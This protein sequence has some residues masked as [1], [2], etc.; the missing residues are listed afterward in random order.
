MQIEDNITF[1][2]DEV[3]NYTATDILRLMDKSAFPERVHKQ[4][5]LAS[6]HYAKALW[7]LRVLNLGSLL[8]LRVPPS[9]M[10]FTFEEDLSSF[11]P[12]AWLEFGNED[13]NES[14]AVYHRASRGSSPR[15]KSGNGTDAATQSDD[16]DD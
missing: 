6:G 9:Q 11:I 8:L 1:L 2:A 12:P 13:L 3:A 7:N 16:I 15:E 10:A 5:S 4:L 14:L